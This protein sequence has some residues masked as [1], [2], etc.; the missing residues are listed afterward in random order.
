[1]FSEGI[2]K[3]QWKDVLISVTPSSSLATWVEP[4]S[5][6]LATNLIWDEFDKITMTVMV[7]R[8]KKVTL[9]GNK[10]AYKFTKLFYKSLQTL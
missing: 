1:M 9:S 3:D 10:R 4:L 7:N 2:G 8:R 5:S 6:R